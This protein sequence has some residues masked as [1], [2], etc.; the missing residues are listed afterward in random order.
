MVEFFK[1]NDA[2]ELKYYN[3]A[4]PI[5]NQL[6][7]SKSDLYNFAYFTYMLGDLIHESDRSPLAKNIKKTLFRQIFQNLFSSFAYAGSFESYIT[8]FKAIFGES[9]NVE[10]TIPGPGKLNILIEPE[11]VILNNFAV[12]SIVDDAYVYDNLLTNDWSDKIM[13][14]T[15]QGVETEYELEQMLYEMVPAGIYTE[16]TLTV[17]S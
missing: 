1:D 8:V 4:A 9:T 14:Q 6:S 17:G 7:N 2:E 12:R 3:S 16:F 15:I 13:L 11:G 10:F 5:L